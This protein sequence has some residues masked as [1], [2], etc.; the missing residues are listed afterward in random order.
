MYLETPRKKVNKSSKEVFWFFLTKW[1]FWDLM[2]KILDKVWGNNENRAL[3]VCNLPGN[4]G[5]CTGKKD[6]KLGIPLSFGAAVEKIA[7]YLNKRYY[8]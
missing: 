4:A 6:S 1:E 7:L 8:E 5:N 2:L 3:L